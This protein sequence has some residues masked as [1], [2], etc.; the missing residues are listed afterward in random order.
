MGQKKKIRVSGEAVTSNGTTWVN[1]AQLTISS[2]ADC[3]IILTDA[4][5]SGTMSTGAAGMAKFEHRAKRV[6]GVM[7]LVGS[8]VYLVTHNTGSD[9]TV[10][11]SASRFLVSGDVIYLQ[12]R[13]PS[14]I[15][16]NWYGE[17]T[18]IIN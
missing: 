1:L 11:G 12:V 13:G 8:I 3:G 18:A 4:V 5:V 9:T 15:N 2:P 14:V 16:V 7:S 10:Q 6:S 17:F